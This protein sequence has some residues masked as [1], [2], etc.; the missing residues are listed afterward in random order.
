[1]E[2]DSTSPTTLSEADSEKSQAASANERPRFVVKAHDFG[3][4]PEFE[5]VNFNHLADQL[6]DEAIIEKLTHGC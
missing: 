3:L 4:R 6:E 2:Q 1:M 5:N